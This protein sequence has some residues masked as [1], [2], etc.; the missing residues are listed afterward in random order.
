MTSL[1]WVVVTLMINQDD[2]EFVRY[3]AENFAM[4]EYK[5]QEEVMTVIKYLT[6][7]LSTT[8]VQILEAFS[9]SHLLAQL[10]TPL[11]SIPS[12][13]T[14]VSHPLAPL[15]ADAELKFRTDWKIRHRWY[16]LQATL[17][18]LPWPLVYHRSA[19]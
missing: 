4:L 3:M 9:P 7:F 18:H 5:T 12:D 11:A 13:V 2:V 6:N 19:L 15:S 16:K 14:T 17:P 10:H 8:G 1:V